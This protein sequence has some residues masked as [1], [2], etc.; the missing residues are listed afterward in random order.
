MQQLCCRLGI[1]HLR[2]SPYHPQT[3]GMLERFHGTLK[4]M[5]R[6]TGVNK[7]DWDALIPFL[8]FAYRDTPHAVT[9]FT[10]FELIFG[11]HV[12]G[13]LAILKSTWIRDN[14]D[15]EDQNV[16]EW[17]TQLGDSLQE[18]A[19]IAGEREKKCKKKCS[20]TMTRKQE[21]ECLKKET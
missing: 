7:K 2:T 3:D 19:L 10:P 14:T 9:G 16:L 4:S 18:M 13:S 11:R 12:R 6:K 20:C 17:V 1:Q 5:I 8:L 21:N 15:E